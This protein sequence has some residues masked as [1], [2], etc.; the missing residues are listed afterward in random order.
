M[1]VSCSLVHC[2]NNPNYSYNLENKMGNMFISE[3]NYDIK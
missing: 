2:L 3:L 1:D